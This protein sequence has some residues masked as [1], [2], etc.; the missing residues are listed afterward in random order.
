VFAAGDV[1]TLRGEPRPR[2]GV[3][4]VR[5]GPPLAAN[6]RAALEGR[7][8]APYRPQRRA[9][10]LL[11]CGE[12]HAVGTWG[13]LSWEGRWVWNWKDRIDRRF[14]ARFRVEA[15]PSGIASPACGQGS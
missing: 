3:Y 1:A 2:S 5:A 12:R 15:E 8:A 6:L 14:V 13:P 4:A 9:L 7:A 10:A 11:S